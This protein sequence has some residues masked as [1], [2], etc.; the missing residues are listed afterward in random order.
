MVKYCCTECQL[1]DLMNHKPM[2]KQVSKM[3][4][5]TMV[6]VKKHHDNRSE[7]LDQPIDL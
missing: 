2:C 4:N 5:D 7:L 6:E 3:I 1:S